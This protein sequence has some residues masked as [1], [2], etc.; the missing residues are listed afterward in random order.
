[1]NLMNTN[2]YNQPTTTTNNTK[3]TRTRLAARAFELSGTARCFLRWPSP[4]EAPRRTSSSA[5]AVPC[6]SAAAAA[7]P[8]RNLLLRHDHRRGVGGGGGGGAGGRG[9]RLWLTRNSIEYVFVEH[10]LHFLA[11]TQRA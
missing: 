11:P 1:M 10:K 7:A 3:I 9:W 6:T 4:V 2:N 8:P 5:A